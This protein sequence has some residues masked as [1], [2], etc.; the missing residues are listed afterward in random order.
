MDVKAIFVSNYLLQFRG[1]KQKKSYRNTAQQ[2]IN[3]IL[4]HMFLK[5]VP[6]IF[7]GVTL[8]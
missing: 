7:V 8:R 2:T 5:V 3:T 4:V 6:N 1:N